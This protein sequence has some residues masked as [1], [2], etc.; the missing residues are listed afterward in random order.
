MF[1]RILLSLAFLSSVPAFAASPAP[2]AIINEITAEPT[3]GGFNPAYVGVR[4]QGFIQAGGNACQAGA[5]K[6]VLKSTIRHGR[7]VFVPRLI[8]VDADR[9]C[10]MFF[11]PNHKGVP[12]NQTVIVKES[13]LEQTFV[14][15]VGREGNL[16]S[17]EFL[18]NAN[19]PI[20]NEAG[21]PEE[22]SCEIPR[23]CT[24]EFIPHVCR[25][26]QGNEFRGNNRCTAIE[27]A[28]QAACANDLPFV[29]SELTCQSEF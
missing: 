14:D 29:P 16:V 8:L 6:A 10:P 2:K 24:M 17:L 1:A 25:D 9:V 22:E 18:L 12:F 20:D 4:L 26:S 15:N 5:Y 3:N 11:D 7:Q 19:A 13:A 28:R 21:L 23:M 27:N